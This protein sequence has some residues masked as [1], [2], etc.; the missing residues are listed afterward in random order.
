MDII[1]QDKGITLVA[2]V[3]TIVVMLIIA[4]VSVNIGTE[5]LDATRLNGFYTKLEVV[6]KR[7]DDIAST[8]ESYTDSKGNIV[9][10]KEQGTAYESLSS[11][12]QEILKNILQSEAA[13]LEP[14]IS[15]FRY[16]TTN[17]LKN[18]LDIS[19]VEYNVFIDFDNRIIIAEDGIKVNGVTYHILKNKVYFPN[20]NTDKNVGTIE[21]LSYSAIKYGENYKIT[22]TPSNA[23][24]DLNIEGTLKYKKATTKYWETSTNLEMVV[25]ELTDYD[26][27]YIDVNNNSLTKTINLST[28]EDGELTVTEK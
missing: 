5:S 12:Q 24:G 19:E 13:Y 26:I 21:Q 9:Y 16:F 25:N 27:I 28:N 1:K 4:G 22:V 14:N 6:Q 11:T 15:N 23:V 2:L 8:N 20:E 3:I 10:L 17:Q 18:I 7:V